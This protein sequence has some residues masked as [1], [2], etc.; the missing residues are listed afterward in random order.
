[1][2]ESLT[3]LVS[4]SPWTY[5]VV[6]AL[7]ALDAVFPL[8]PSEATVI[9]A[10]VLAGTGDL[11]VALVLAAAAVGALVGDHLGYAVGRGAGRLS[12]RPLRGQA[13]AER[14][15]D[16]RGPYL[17]VIA[18]FIPG[19]RTAATVTA[20]LTRMARRRFLAAAALAAGLWASFATAL[21]YVGGRAFEDEPWR[22]LVA[23]FV[24]A[25]TLTTGVEVGR[26]LVSARRS[27]GCAPQPARA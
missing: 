23:A 8:V 3:Q 11:H 24:V 18:R 16:E 4:G 14:Q 10:G 12:T 26:R 22:G 7:A 2:L 17:L 20:G 15:L 27:R 1:L 25:A 21:G 9:A 6:A 19:G 13:W 5:A